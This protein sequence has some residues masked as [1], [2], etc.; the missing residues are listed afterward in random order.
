MVF[1]RGN[2]L[3]IFNIK[4]ILVSIII[5]MLIT[6]NIYAA[7]IDIIGITKYNPCGL[8][9][10][11]YIGKNIEGAE[12][13]KPKI[14]YVKKP[15]DVIKNIPSLKIINPK[16]LPEGS[17][18]DLVDEFTK[19]YPEGKIRVNPKTNSL[20]FTVGSN[21]AIYPLDNVFEIPATVKGG[22]NLF[23]FSD[24][25]N[26]YAIKGGRLTKISDDPTKLVN[27]LN[28]MG[29]PA[30]VSQLPGYKAVIIP[31]NGPNVIFIPGYKPYL[32]KELPR[33]K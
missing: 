10:T 1:K 24:G 19:A 22:S 4:F 11:R 27:G 29:I 5:T 13:L 12:R 20:S 18:P 28:I 32:S 30:S 23:L 9:I 25:P 14:P 17:I 7:K 26:A 33:V 8:D 16:E 21:T 15:G 31:P 3:K 6:N 2:I